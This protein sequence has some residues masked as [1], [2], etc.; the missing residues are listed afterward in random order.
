M[1]NAELGRKANCGEGTALVPPGL[2]VV[3]SCLDPQALKLTRKEGE[4]FTLKATSP[5]QRVPSRAPGNVPS[6]P[7]EMASY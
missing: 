2:F 4:Q 6:A 1:L 5:F 7:P 3:V